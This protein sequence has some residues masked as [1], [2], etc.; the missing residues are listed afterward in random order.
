MANRFLNRVFLADAMTCFACFALLVTAAD[1]LAPLLGLGAGLLRGAGWLLLP[2]AALFGWIA[3][4]DRPP[5]PMVL[6]GIVGNLAW[7]AASVAVIMM[8]QPT[9]IGIAFV[10]AQAAA[11]L[12]L[13][14]LEYRGFRQTAAAA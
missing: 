12:L 6:L 8:M 4:R 3:T 14:A 13:A 5:M 11:V 9:P 7:V 1:S 10:A 2:V